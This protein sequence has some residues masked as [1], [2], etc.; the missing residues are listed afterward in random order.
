MEYIEEER[1]GGGPCF[2]SHLTSPKGWIQ[3]SFGRRS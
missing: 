1:G 3:A 2:W